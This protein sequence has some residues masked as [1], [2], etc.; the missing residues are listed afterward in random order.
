MDQEKKKYLFL[1]AW[2]KAF[3]E[4]ECELGQGIRIRDQG[5]VAFLTPGSGILNRFFPDLLSRIP[6][7]YF[8]E[9]SDYILGEKFYNSL[10]IG[11]NF[12]SSFQK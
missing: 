7:P 5:S 1:T 12:F 8:G 6:N 9:L 11:L 2:I 4:R 3:C 10:K